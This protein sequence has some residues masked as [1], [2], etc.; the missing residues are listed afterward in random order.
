MLVGDFVN[1]EAPSSETTFYAP[2]VYDATGRKSFKD[3]QPCDLKF[4][5]IQC[6][7]D[8]AVVGVAGLCGASAI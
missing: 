2:V 7:L 8:G 3:S 4:V 6:S 5:L 1:L